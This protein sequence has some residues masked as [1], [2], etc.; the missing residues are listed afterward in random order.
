M[1]DSFIT[2]LDI[3]Y[4]FAGLRLLLLIFVFVTMKLPLTDLVL[5]I[6]RAAR[7]NTME[8]S[9]LSFWS[10]SYSDVWKGFFF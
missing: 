3:V 9:A 8:C 5:V 4:C 6:E 7:S 2:A 10:V 1:I